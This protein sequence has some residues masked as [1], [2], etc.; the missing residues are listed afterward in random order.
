MAFRTDPTDQ[1]LA[2]FA[3]VEPGGKLMIFGR[4]TFLYE[5][6]PTPEDFFRQFGFAEVHTL[7]VSPYQGAS[8]IFD[9]NSPEPPPDLV[10]RYRFVLSGGT[11]EHVFNIVNAVRTAVALLEPGGIF[12]FAVPCNNWVDHGFYQISPTFAFDYFTEN[13]LE[14][15][16]SKARLTEAKSPDSISIPLYPGEAI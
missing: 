1:Y 16:K 2:A 3:E 10:G 7:D 12:E 4:P 15:L 11:L 9:L 8:H 5:G 14:F 13:G 6:A